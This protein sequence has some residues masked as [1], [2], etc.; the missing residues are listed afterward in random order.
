MTLSPKSRRL[1]F[2][3][4]ELLIVL[5]L[6]GV[7]GSVAATSIGRTLAAS[8]VDR[9]AAVVAGELQKARALA[10]RVRRPMV[11]VIGSRRVRIQEYGT[12]TL[13]SDLRLTAA[14]EI[15]VQ[16]L[17]TTEGLVVLFPNGMADSNVTLTI[18]ENG[19]A[20]RITMTRAGLIR[21]TTP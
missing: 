19:H 21:V 18:R 16:S 10:S 15:G 14:S 13:H 12:G 11:V 3:M 7:A 5:I 1:G 8:K 6:M 2:S 17:L 4:T 9:T 20:R